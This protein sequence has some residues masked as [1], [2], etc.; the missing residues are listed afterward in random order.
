MCKTDY[1]TSDITSYDTATA[2]RTNSVWNDNMRRTIS[3]RNKHS[4]STRKIKRKREKY[5]QG[6]ANDREHAEWLLAK[7]ICEGVD[8]IYVEKLHPPP[9]T[10]CLLW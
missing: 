2:F 1:N 9:P 8:V 7:K 4:N 6:N 3:H 10:A 5:N